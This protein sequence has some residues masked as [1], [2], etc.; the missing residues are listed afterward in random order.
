MS[1]FDGGWQVT[2]HAPQGDE[3]MTLALVADPPSGTLSGPDGTSAE[4]E[5]LVIDG[6]AATW[7]ARIT[8]PM[9]VTIAFK[10]NVDGDSM[11]GMATAA[12]MIKMPFDG[13]RS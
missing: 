10:A 12:A 7:R 9:P 2:L 1:G 6:D 5:S 8:K 4:V 13:T 11:T 3:H